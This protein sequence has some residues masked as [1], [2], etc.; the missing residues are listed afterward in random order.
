M[1]TAPFPLFRCRITRNESC[2][3]LS[4][5]VHYDFLQQKL[6]NLEDENRKLR[7][8]V[9]RRWLHT[10]VTQRCYIS[11]C[12]T[13]VLHLVLLIGVQTVLHTVTTPVTSLKVVVA[14]TQGH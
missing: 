7:L 12:Y 14:P 3:S 9:R 8:E 13:L 4:N 11:R 1:L 2:S 6:K 10:V 5:F